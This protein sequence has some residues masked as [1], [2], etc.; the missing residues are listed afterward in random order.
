MGNAE[1]TGLTI[2]LPR[3]Q[4]DWPAEGWLTVGE[5]PRHRRCG[6]AASLGALE[7]VVKVVKAADMTFLPP[8]TTGSAGL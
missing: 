4:P 8:T 7:V 5:S 6:P 2:R 1:A 3:D